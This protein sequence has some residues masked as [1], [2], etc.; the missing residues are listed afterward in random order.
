MYEPEAA[1]QAIDS[2]NFTIMAF[3]SITVIF[4][5]LYFLIGFRMTLRQKV[6]VVPFIGSALFFW[7]DLSFVMQYDLWFNVYDHWWLKMWWF[8]LVGTVALELVMLWQVYRYGHQ[9]LWPNLP[10]A[11]FGGLIM[12]GTL[13][14]GALWYLVKVSIQDEL[15]F[16]TFAITAVFSVPFHTA[17]MSRRRSRSGQSIA[18]ELSTIVMLWSLTAVFIKVAPFFSTAPYLLF[19][20]TFTAWPLFNVL[21][22]L[23]LPAVATAADQSGRSLVRVAMAQP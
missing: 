10:K 13:G 15:Y 2:N 7:H 21:L 6:Y 20:A 22:I 19:V 11:A 17:I 9:E 4:A 12:L 18:M 16:I 23:K 3:L 8:A 1:L 14:I 5:F